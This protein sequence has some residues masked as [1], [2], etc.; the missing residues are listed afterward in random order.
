LVCFLFRAPPSTSVSLQLF[1]R[2]CSPELFSTHVVGDGC[3]LFNRIAPP[4]CPPRLRFGFRRRFCDVVL[5][6]CSFVWFQPFSFCFHLLSLT[7]QGGCA[8]GSYLRRLHCLL[9]L[10]LCCWILLGWLMKWVLF[11]DLLVGIFFLCSVADKARK[12]LE[13]VAI[14]ASCRLVS[15]VRVDGQI[16][17]PSLKR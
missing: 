3:F 17:P 7:R 8:S 15:L 12:G 5:P 11:S 13:L 10:L 6:M 2:R 14:V 1:R 16:R 4:L 9:F